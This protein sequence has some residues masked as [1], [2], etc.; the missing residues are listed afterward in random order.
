M[1][2]IGCSA[3]VGLDVPP[4]DNAK[5]S[6]WDCPAPAP[7]VVQD[8]LTPMSEIRTNEMVIPAEQALVI[9]DFEKWAAEQ[10]VK[11]GERFGVSAGICTV[12]DYSNSG[13]ETGH[14][15]EPNILLIHAVAP[16]GK[17]FLMPYQLH[18]VWEHEY[19]HYLKFRRTGDG[20]DSYGH[21]KEYERRMIR[22]QLWSPAEGK[23]AAIQKIAVDPPLPDPA[24]KPTKTCTGKNCKPASRPATPPPPPPATR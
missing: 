4:P 7:L 2:A 21:D 19:L 18:Y 23:G 20:T 15:Y 5:C 11:N 12:I 9:A 10:S 6:G 22:L 8:K 17:S 24:P 16:D 14:W 3:H 13:T 1:L